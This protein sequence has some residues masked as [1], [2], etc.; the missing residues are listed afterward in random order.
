VLKEESVNLSW[1]NEYVPFSEHSGPLAIF[2]TIMAA[3][4]HLKST[5]PQQIVSTKSALDSPL[6]MILLVAVL[7]FIAGWYLRK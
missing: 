6:I 4:Q 3:I 2:Q 1:A 5:P 7:A